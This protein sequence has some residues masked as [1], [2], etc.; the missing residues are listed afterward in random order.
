MLAQRTQ[1]WKDTAPQH[2]IIAAGST[3]SILAT[4]N[5]LKVISGLPKG[6]VEIPL[7]AFFACLLPSHVLR[8]ASVTYKYFAFKN[9]YPYVN[10][11]FEMGAQPGKEVSINFEKDDFLTDYNHA[12]II[13]I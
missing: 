13:Y 7:V 9:G 12:Y 2:P 11:A 6:S 1:D 8:V 3:G 5:L 10:D 4:A